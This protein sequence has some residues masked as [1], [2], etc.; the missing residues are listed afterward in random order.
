MLTPDEAF[1]IWWI[2]NISAIYE[3]WC[4]E[5]ERQYDDVN[6]EYLENIRFRDHVEWLFET[7]YNK[8]ERY[9]E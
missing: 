4:D 9:T 2:K 7:E 5:N 1:D 8:D 3:D 6:E